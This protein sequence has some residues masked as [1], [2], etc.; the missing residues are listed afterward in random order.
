MNVLLLFIILLIF[1]GIGYVVY[2]KKSDKNPSDPAGGHDGGKVPVKGEKINFSI[3]WVDSEPQA[4]TKYNSNSSDNYF[5]NVNTYRDLLKKWSDTLVGMRICY[6][7][8]ENT[9]IF[10]NEGEQIEDLDKI[11]DSSVSD[12]INITAH[13]KPG[14]Y[15]TRFGTEVKKN[16]RNKAAPPAFLI[17][18][19]VDFKKKFIDVA[20]GK[21]YGLFS[22]TKK[23]CEPIKTKSRCLDKTGC[24]WYSFMKEDGDNTYNWT[25]K[26]KDTDDIW[27]VKAKPWTQGIT[28]S[29]EQTNL[30]KLKDL[31]TTDW[32]PRVLGF[33]PGGYCPD[34]TRWNDECTKYVFQD[35]P[36]NYRNPYTFVP[37]DADIKEILEKGLGGGKT[38]TN[39]GAYNSDKCDF[40][41]E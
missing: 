1:S 10:K 41:S 34:Q 40:C 5:R 24:K 16:I 6:N 12:P 30:T 2:K 35:S 33:A 4:N 29:W 20:N 39:T 21:C 28:D 8:D 14:Y 25:S 26:F 17:N 38:Y 7:C 22:S 31:P 19:S 37:V 9:L 32:D 3:N 15:L 23:D 36:G 18:T 13:T 27:I 11:I